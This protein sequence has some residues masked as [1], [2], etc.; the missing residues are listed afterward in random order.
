M[1]S[2]SSVGTEIAALPE[3]WN[4]NDRRLGNR[5]RLSLMLL[6]RQEEL[7]LGSVAQ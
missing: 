6:N 5:D 7:C 4:S 3:E 1:C 2:H